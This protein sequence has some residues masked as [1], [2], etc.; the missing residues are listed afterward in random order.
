MGFIR[1]SVAKLTGAD[2]Q[3]DIATRQ[4]D[5]QAQAVRA[6]SEAAAKATQEQAA[7]A[8]KLQE[9]A[10]ARAVAQAAAADKAETPI[11]SPDV[12]LTP[13]VGSA[14][15]NARKKRQSFGIGAGGTGV[16]I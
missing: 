12:Q 16:N 9:A 15:G 13:N 4:A 7:Q 14:I 6:A 10:T 5:E 8:A 2:V 3:A 11:Q 1:Q